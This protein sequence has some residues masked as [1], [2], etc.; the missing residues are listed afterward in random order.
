MVNTLRSQLV[1]HMDV[2]NA[3]SRMERLLP[4][5]PR[6]SGRDPAAAASLNKDL[7]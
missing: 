1:T 4:G 7:Q 3:V 6:R 2:G 5:D